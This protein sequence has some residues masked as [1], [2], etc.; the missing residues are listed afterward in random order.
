MIIVQPEPAD[1]QP[2]APGPSQDTINA[3]PTTIQ[4]AYEI[5]RSGE[6]TSLDELV[7]QLKAERF[8]GVDGH[9]ASA[10]VRRDLRQISQSARRHEAR[11]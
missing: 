11:G 2:R 8:E 1:A 10:S 7:L 6:C 3:G 5:A 4:R 9:I